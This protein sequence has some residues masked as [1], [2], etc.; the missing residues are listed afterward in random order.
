MST[1][2]GTF[3][4][5]SSAEENTTPLDK[6]TGTY[7]PSSP[8]DLRSPCPMINALANHNYLFHDGRNITAADFSSAM[9]L[10]GL[11]PFLGALFSNAVFLEHPTPTPTSSPSAPAPGFFA[12]FLSRLRAILANPWEILPHR[13]GVLLPCNLRTQTNPEGRKVRVLNLDQLSLHGA[14]EHD[15]SLSRRDTLQGD[16]HTPQ[17]DLIEQILSAASSDGGKTFSMDD[18]CALRRRRIE[19]QRLKNPELQ[20]GPFEHELGCGE[21]ALLL[22]VFGDGTRVRSDYLR[23]FFVEERLPIKEGWR[24]GRRS[25][26]RALG[27]VG[28]KW[29]VEKVKRR[30]GSV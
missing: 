28:L 21:I 14:I 13:L 12:S 9:S 5:K 4:D 7:T 16:N 20:Y 8:S 23:A 18:L 17:A 3:L 29:T 30:I 11:S 22:K 26:W 19:T 2:T 1:S 6:G 10:V 25:W 27:L 24:I 15:I